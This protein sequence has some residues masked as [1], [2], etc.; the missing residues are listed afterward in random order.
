MGRSAK[1]KF[2]QMK[3]R[4]VTQTTSQRVP[5]HRQMRERPSG[6]VANRSQPEGSLWLDKPVTLTLTPYSLLLRLTPV[7]IRRLVAD[8]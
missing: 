7:V 5:G 1:V 2:S 4:S 3:P 6:S 8:A